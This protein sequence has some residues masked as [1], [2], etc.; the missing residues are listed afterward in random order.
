MPTKRKADDVVEEQQ[1]T[2]PVENEI[3]VLDPEFAVVELESGLEVRVERLKLRQLMKLVKII[4]AGGS[5]DVLFAMDYEDDADFIRKLLALTISSIPVAEDETFDFIR[6]L[7]VPKHYI[8]KP[9]TKAEREANEVALDDL[10]AEM[11]NPEIS[12]VITILT[13]L[14]RKEAPHISSLGK[15]IAAL[16]PA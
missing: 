14:F 1:E 16:L 8:E 3:D 9:R 5:L 15:K 13:V 11:A 7:V 6:S 2:T 4:T 10:N 12:D